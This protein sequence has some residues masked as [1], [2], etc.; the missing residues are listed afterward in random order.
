M[1][2]RST[3]R[4]V[5]ANRSITAPMRNSC[6]CF[7]KFAGLLPSLQFHP[8]RADADAQRRRRL[9]AVPAEL[10]ERAENHLLF[11]V[12]QRLARQALNAL[13]LAA[14]RVLSHGSIVAARITPGVALQHDRALDDVL[15]LAH[16]SRPGVALQD[17]NRLG[18]DV[19]ERVLVALGDLVQEMPRTAR[20]C[21]RCDAAAAAVRSARRSAGRYRSCRNFPAAT[22]S[23][24]L[25]LVVAMTRTSTCCVSELPTRSNCTFLQ[26][27]QQLGLQAPARS[28]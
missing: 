17:A 26:H 23:S 9:D 21:P 18:L 20:G 25:R 27:A 11:D 7:D 15:K 14:R 28:R 16:I 24:R 1:R 12:R 22:S 5:A 6:A 19:P 3:A 8:K 2:S 4:G 13:R 10:L